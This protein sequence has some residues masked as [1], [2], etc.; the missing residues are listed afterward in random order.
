MELDENTCA[1]LVH[2]R[3]KMAMEAKVLVSL[4]GQNIFTLH[5]MMDRQR[6]G[7]TGERKKQEERTVAW[8]GI[9]STVLGDRRKTDGNTNRRQNE[10]ANGMADMQAQNKNTNKQT[11]CSLPECLIGSVC[12]YTP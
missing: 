8:T 2:N 10:Q 9:S 4:I 5:T 11:L 1:I 3:R 6:K 12:R 7:R